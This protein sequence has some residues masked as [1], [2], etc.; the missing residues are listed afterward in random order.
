MPSIFS[1]RDVMAC[2]TSL[3][4]LSSCS[5]FLCTRSLEMLFNSFRLR[6]NP[7]VESSSFLIR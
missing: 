6:T 4:V 5:L 7:S 3:K 1:S 2:S